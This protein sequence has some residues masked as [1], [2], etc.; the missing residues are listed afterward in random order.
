MSWYAEDITLAKV[1]AQPSQWL[2]ASSLTVIFIA[3][4]IAILSAVSWSYS[5]S[6]DKFYNLDGVWHLATAWAFFTKRY[7]FLRE[8]FKKTKLKMF[9]FRLLQVSLYSTLVVNPG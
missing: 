8:N 1:L 5:S 4:S 6:D 2:R 9:R 3:L 7:D